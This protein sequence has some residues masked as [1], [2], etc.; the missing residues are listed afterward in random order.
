MS[1]EFTAKSKKLLTLCE[2]EG[3]DIDSLLEGAVF[4]S[5]SPGICMTEGCNY[6]CEI[7]GDQTA[8]YCE[9]CGGQTVVSALILAGVM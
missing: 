9:A 1:L 5:I 7:E 2:A 6:T 3:L 4:D 8:G